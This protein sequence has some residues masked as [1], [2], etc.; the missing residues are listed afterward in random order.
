MQMLPFWFNHLNLSNERLVSEYKLVTNVLWGMGIVGIVPIGLATPA[1]TGA[2]KGLAAARGQGARALVKGVAGQAA[3]DMVGSF[4]GGMGRR[5]G[6]VWVIGTIAAE[7]MKDRQG[8]L[9]AELSRRFANGR[10][11]LS[12]YQQAMGGDAAIPYVY[13]HRVR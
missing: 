5:L 12:L 6:A 7:G 8:V 3:K 9:A 1:A 4:T 2:I 10:F 13:F 11:P